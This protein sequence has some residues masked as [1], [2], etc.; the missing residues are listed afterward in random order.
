MTEQNRIS[1][2][3]YRALLQS[4]SGI[5]CGYVL[6]NDVIIVWSNGSNQNN[7]ANLEFAKGH[8]EEFRLIE[9]DTETI[10]R[11]E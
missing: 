10:I 6:P 9:I 3:N 4:R 5:P 8:F 7:Y 11:R 2:L 1:S